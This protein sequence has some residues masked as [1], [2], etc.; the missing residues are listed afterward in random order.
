MEST[1]IKQSINNEIGFPKCYWL[2]IQKTLKLIKAQYCKIKSQAQKLHPD[3]GDQ[4]ICQWLNKFIIVSGEVWKAGIKEF[5]CESGVKVE[6][7]YIE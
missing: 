2:T 7:I 4:L 1:Y 6:R 3:I 5:E